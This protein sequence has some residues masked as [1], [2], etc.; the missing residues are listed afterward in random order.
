[1]KV[2][3]VKILALSWTATLTLL[4]LIIGFTF[5]MA[6]NRYDQRKIYEEE[7]ANAIGTEYLRA[8]LLPAADA[9][10]VRTLLLNYLDQRVLFY[11]Y[12]RSATASADRCPNC[13]IAGRAVVRGPDSGGCAAGA[14][15]RPGGCRHERRVELAGLHAGSMV[16]P[17]SD[18]GMGLDGGDRHLLQ[19]AGWLWCEKR[20]TE[21]H[22]ASGS[23]ACCFHRILSHCGHRQP[24]LGPYSRDPTKSPK[25]LSI[26]AC[27]VSDT[28]AGEGMGRLGDLLF[29]SDYRAESDATQRAQRARGDSHFPRS[30][31]RNYLKIPLP[32]WE[33]LGEGEGSPR[34]TPP[35]SLPH[36]GGG[37]LGDF[38][39]ITKRSSEE[40][41]SGRRHR[42]HQHQAGTD[43][44][45][46]GGAAHIG[47]TATP[48]DHRG[49]TKMIEPTFVSRLNI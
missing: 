27:A 28:S 20:Y 7:E 36:Q 46:D 19:R 33:G 13:Q 23:A 26:P 49:T 9:A 32:R 3:R 39:I 31:L 25:P 17:H 38:E 5:S 47:S 40:H 48:R 11:S 15:Y 35:P 34:I 24:T 45:N 21:I 10:K 2:R 41:D 37:D 6:L 14:R 29:H 8:E 4:A 44:G 18:C 16:E 12:P 22:P 43:W 30:A 1:M 42:R